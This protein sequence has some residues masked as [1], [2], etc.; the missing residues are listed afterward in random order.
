MAGAAAR[1]GAAKFAGSRMS[2][3]RVTGRSS[4]YALTAIRFFR[5][6]G[7]HT[8]FLHYENFNDLLFVEQ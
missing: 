8:R 2:F 3:A 7:P 5:L 1:R 6:T 4:S